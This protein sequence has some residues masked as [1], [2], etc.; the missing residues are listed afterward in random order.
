[1]PG[2]RLFNRQL[3]LWYF[4][5]LIANELDLVFT[6]FGLSRGLFLEANPLVRPLL[7]TLWPVVVKFGGLALLAPCIAAV[8]RTTLW[9]QRLVLGMVQI[10]TW[11]YGIVL[12][13]HLLYLLTAIASV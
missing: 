11:V 6:Y 7:F 13:M 3:W 2:T 9:R 10:A 12:L 5:L 4:L 1:M 8:L